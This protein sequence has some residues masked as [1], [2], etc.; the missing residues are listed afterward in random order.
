[1]TT[2][3]K[4]LC[5]ALAAL[6]VAG[7]VLGTVLYLNNRPFN[8]YKEDI[9]KYIGLDTEAYKDYTIEM[10]L[11]AI[12]ELSVDE[13]INQLLNAIGVKAVIGIVA[14]DKVFNGSRTDG[15]FSV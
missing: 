9:S 13:R 11:D 8:Y 2:K 3:S 4:I 1:M 6:L 7:A 12:T 15:V 14:V 10:K 5:V